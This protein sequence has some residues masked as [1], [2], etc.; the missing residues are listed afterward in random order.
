LVKNSETEISRL[1]A[2]ISTAVTVARGFASALSSFSFSIG[3]AIDDWFFSFIDC[4]QRSA[5][6]R[7]NVAGSSI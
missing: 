6:D 5:A 2:P 3:L 1:R 7:R 4:R